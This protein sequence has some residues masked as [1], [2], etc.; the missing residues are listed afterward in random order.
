MDEVSLRPERPGDEAAIAGVIGDAFDG[1]GEALLVDRL[2]AAGAL[3]CSLLAE[4]GGEVVGHV[5]LSPVTIDGQ[6]GHGRWLGL[7]PLAVAA[8]HRRRGLGRRL[9]E[10]ALAAAA[11]RHADLVFVLG[12]PDYYAGLGFEEAAPLGWQC[13]YEVPT[14]AF[15]V[16]RPGPSSDLPVTG[17]VHYHHAFDSL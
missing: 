14:G 15:R 13:I 12:R 11:E 4:V 3:D 5:A 8:G 9:V 10:H 1:D 6:A 7:A 16:W 17:T 2:R